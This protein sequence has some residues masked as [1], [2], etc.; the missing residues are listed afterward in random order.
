MAGVAH[1]FSLSVVPIGHSGST[2]GSP[3]PRR[4]EMINR[5]TAQDSPDGEWFFDWSLKIEPIE[6]RRGVRCAPQ[7]ADQVLPTSH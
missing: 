3:I 7:Y 1:L 2:L 4:V 5:T 6:A